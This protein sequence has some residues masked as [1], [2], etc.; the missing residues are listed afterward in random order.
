M[1]QSNRPTVVTE[2][3]GQEGQEPQVTGLAE[4]NAEVLESAPGMREA[5]LMMLAEVPTPDDD[6]SAAAASIIGTI[7]AAE[8]A[9]ELDKPWDSDGMRDYFDQVV[10]VRRIT[11]RPSD[12]TG[13]LGVYLGCDCYIE[14]TGQEMFISCGGVSAVAQLVRAHT[15]GALPL[16]VI[17]VRAKKAT[18]QGYWPYHLEVMKNRLAQ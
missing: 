7:L 8:N 15:L 13:G 1:T 5:F 6:P 10:I 11:K 3:E 16:A 2:Q 14:S 12:F 18:K 9:A 4:Y 17:P